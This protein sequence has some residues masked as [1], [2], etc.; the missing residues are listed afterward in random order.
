MLRLNSSLDGVNL[1]TLTADSKTKIDDLDN[2]GKI[3][4]NNS[5]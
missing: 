3:P 5:S 4:W 1:P 2:L